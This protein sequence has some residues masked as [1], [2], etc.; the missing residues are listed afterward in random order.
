MK[1]YVIDFEHIQKIVCSVKVKANSYEEAMD[2]FEK[3]PFEN[4][5]DLE[6]FPLEEAENKGF[7]VSSVTEDGKEV[8]K[9]IRK[10]KAELTV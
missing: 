10:F 6:T 2:I 8:Y 4:V 7:H 3:N 9:D 1:K 5:I